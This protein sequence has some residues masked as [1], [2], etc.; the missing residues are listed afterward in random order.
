MPS[1]ELM[2]CAVL[3]LRFG[4]ASQRLTIGQI[5]F[6]ALLFFVAVT[7][8]TFLDVSAYLDRVASSKHSALARPAFPVIRSVPPSPSSGPAG[9]PS[10]PTKPSVFLK[11]AALPPPPGIIEQG[12]AQPVRGVPPTLPSTGAPTAGAHVPSVVSIRPPRES[13]H[14]R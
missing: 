11:P 13:G 1:S 14:E 4:K 8:A 3:H 6:G 9:S 12:S 7:V 2:G 5:A 10:R